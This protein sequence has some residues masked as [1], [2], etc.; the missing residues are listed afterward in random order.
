MSCNTSILN[1][2]TLTLCYNSVHWHTGCLSHENINFINGYLW[3]TWA[4]TPINGIL[5]F[6]LRVSFQ[7][8]KYIPSKWGALNLICQTYL[9]Q[10]SDV[11][12][13]ATVSQVTGVYIVCSTIFLQAQIKENTKAPRYW[14]L[15]GELTVIDDVIISRVV[16]MKSNAVENHFAYPLLRK[17]YV[18]FTI[19]TDKLSIVPKKITYIR[20]NQRLESDGRSLKWTHL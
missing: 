20:I 12:I 5:G 19:W 4:S 1:I 2:D 8:F 6:M 3:R 15:S 16:H 17:A 9:Y 14:P 10:Y 11:I 13:T 7:I 18:A